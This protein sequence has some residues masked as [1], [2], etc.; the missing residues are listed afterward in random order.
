MNAYYLET[1]YKMKIRACLELCKLRIAVTTTLSAAAGYLLAS[2][3]PEAGA[4]RTLA[5]VF[6]LACGAAA[7]NQYQERSIDAAM[8]RTRRRP[9]PSGRVRPGEALLLSLILLLGGLFL[10]AGMSPA[11]FLLG[12]FAVFWYNGVYTLLKRRTAF[13]VIPGALIG[14]L[15]VAI[16]W[17]SGGGSIRDPKIAFLCFFFF[18]WQ[19]PHFWLL[20]QRYG[21]EYRKAGLPSL[22]SQLSSRQLARINFVWTSAAGMSGIFLTAIGLARSGIVNLILLLLSAML[23]WSSGR[24]FREQKSGPGLNGV[25]RVVN[26]YMVF[27]T[28]VLVVGTFI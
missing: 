10:L 12:S 11:V 2:A 3:K 27:V 22:T 8:Q 14:A 20:V 23:V 26:A 19:V 21:D 24:L 9:L 25:F 16:G 28:L 4:M 15:P 7:L 1:V 6:L 13:A 17:V 5:G 18:M